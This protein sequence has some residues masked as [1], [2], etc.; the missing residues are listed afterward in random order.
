[1]ESNKSMGFVEFLKSFFLPVLFVLELIRELNKIDE[2]KNVKPLLHYLW[3]V[4]I[5]RIVTRITFT[6]MVIILV[7]LEGSI[8]GAIW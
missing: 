4:F 8:W 2:N 5:L 7:I 1:M 6:V 3:M